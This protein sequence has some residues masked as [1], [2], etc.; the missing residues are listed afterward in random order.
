MGF[1][2]SYNDFDLTML[3]KKKNETFMKIFGF[4]KG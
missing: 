3:K 1:N 2:T 4:S